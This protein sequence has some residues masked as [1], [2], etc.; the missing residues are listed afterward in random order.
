MF[1]VYLMKLVTLVRTIYNTPGISHAVDKAALEY[2][3]GRA[4]SSKNKVD[5]KLV[6]IV[7][8]ALQN[9][10]YKAVMN[11]KAKK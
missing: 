3:K 4:Q 5:D 9:K 11:G 1:L 7:D 8:A 2:L 6:Q 10:N